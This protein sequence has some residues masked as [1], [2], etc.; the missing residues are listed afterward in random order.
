MTSSHGN[1]HD[2]RRSLA[3]VSQL[4]ADIAQ[5]AGQLTAIER[6]CRIL[7][8]ALAKYLEGRDLKPPGALL[9]SK[10]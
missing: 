8:R 6:W 5:T 9:P 3:R 10:P 1:G 2:V 7:S 4:L